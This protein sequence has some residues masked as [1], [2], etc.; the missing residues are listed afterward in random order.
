MTGVYYKKE[1]QDSFDCNDF[2]PGVQ[3]LGKLLISNVFLS[4]DDDDD[5]DDDDY[6][7]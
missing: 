5:D 7:L 6:F 2:Q 3:P 1:V 4:A